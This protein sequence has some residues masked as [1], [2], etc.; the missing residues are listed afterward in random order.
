MRSFAF[1]AIVLYALLMRTL[2]AIG[3]LKRIRID[4]ASPVLH[5]NHKLILQSFQGF[6]CPALGFTH[7]FGMRGTSITCF[8]NLAWR[9]LFGMASWALDRIRAGSFAT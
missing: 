4:L 9:T 8:V 3:T 6:V 7:A 5:D 1:C 2:L